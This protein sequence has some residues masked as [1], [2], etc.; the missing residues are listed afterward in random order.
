MAVVLSFRE[1]GAGPPLLI[2]HGLFGSSVNWA[3]MARRLSDQ[4]R[5]LCLDLRNH[6][7]SP[8]AAAMGYP[9]MVADIE[10]FM[11]DHGLASAVVLGH[12]LGGKA[13]MALA[14][15]SPAR[16]GKLIVVDIAPVT[17]SHSYA[18]IVRALRGL[19]L[20]TV[21][22]RTQADGLLAPALPDGRLRQFLL[23]NLAPDDGGYRWRLN[24]DAADQ[25]EPEIKGFPAGE[26]AE[27]YA[28]ETLFIRGALSDYV[29]PEHYPT[30]RRW[31]PIARINVVAHAGHWVHVEQPD[32]F[33]EAVKAFLTSSPHFST[34][35]VDPSS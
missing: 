23:Q 8:H 15:D 25:Y 30:I 18:L 32:A 6:G 24:L 35:V 5:V 16:V 22:S 31:F 26:A 4:Y 28:G 3:S 17:Y 9:D 19:D 11:D 33:Q 13:A 27:P 34:G 21:T 14:I 7:D 10:R 12:S 20:S 29:S 2:L 1:Y